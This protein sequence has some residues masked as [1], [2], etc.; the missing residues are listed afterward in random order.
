MRQ[1]P[2]TDSNHRADITACPMIVHISELSIFIPKVTPAPTT[3]I[4]EL[5]L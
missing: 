1:Y 3:I 5:V 2:L 4:G